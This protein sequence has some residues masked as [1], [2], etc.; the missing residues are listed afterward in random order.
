MLNACSLCL[1]QGSVFDLDVNQQG[2][3]LDLGRWLC[4]VGRSGAL[5]LHA[6][7]T[8]GDVVAE[9]ED[10]VEAGDEEDAPDA[11]GEAAEPE[12]AP[13][14]VL[15][16]LAELEELGDVGRV[17]EG[18]ARHVEHD[19]GAGPLLDHLLEAVEVFGEDRVIL[20]L[21]EDDV[22]RPVFEGHDPSTV[23]QSPGVK[24]R[25]V[26][27]AS[28][29]GAVFLLDALRDPREIEH[30]PARVR[31]QEH[32]AIVAGFGAR[33]RVHRRRGRRSR[34]PARPYPWAARLSIRGRSPIET[35]EDG[36]P[37]H[38]FLPD[39][40]NLGQVG[41]GLKDRRSCTMARLLL[42][43]VG[44]NAL[45]EGFS[46]AGELGQLVPGRGVGIDGLGAAI[47]VRQI[48]RASLEQPDWGKNVGYCCDQKQ[49]DDDHQ[50]IAIAAGR[51]S[52]GG[53]DRS[54]R[55]VDRLRVIGHA[56]S[57]IERRV[58]ATAAGAPGG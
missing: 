37:L 15:H 6:G 22:V 49:Q 55:R 56:G 20:K 24:R 39:A 38:G 19:V 4:E 8:A 5:D 35:Q 57:V 51:D 14:V 36:D 46:E 11:G 44:G 47:R 17:E 9:L 30:R 21:T 2:V 25:A 28:R 41:G 50:R 45:G 32:A 27:G 3:F 7:Q 33:F 23:K 18:D 1:I 12:P 13:G 54:R 40:A 34:K 58:C 10:L 52:R 48:R 53:L 26:P 43:T 16:E 42:A 31:A 29:C